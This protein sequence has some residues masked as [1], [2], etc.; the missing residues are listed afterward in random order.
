[1]YPYIPGDVAINALNDIFGFDGW[2]CEPQNV[3]EEFYVFDD[4]STSL[5]MNIC[6]FTQLL[7]LLQ[8]FG[9]GDAYHQKTQGAAT[10]KAYKGAMTDCIKRTAHQLGRVFNCV[11]DRRYVKFLK[12]PDSVKLF[13]PEQQYCYSWMTAALLDTA[14]RGGG[15]KISTAGAKREVDNSLLVRG[16]KRVYS[17]ARN[18][19]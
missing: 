1:D 13:P 3:T 2:Q 16:F 17:R 9:F 4:P 18:L 5:N 6:R 12:D 14:V 15:H 7:H 8:D 10:D 19:Y 11:Y